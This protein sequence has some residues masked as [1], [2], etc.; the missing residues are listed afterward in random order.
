MQTKKSDVALS[1]R[2]RAIETVP[3]WCRRPVSLVRSRRIGSKPG[4]AGVGFTPACTTS[5]RTL[6]PG[7]LSRRTVR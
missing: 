5:M 1:G 6:W 4:R 3:S 7:W 2:A